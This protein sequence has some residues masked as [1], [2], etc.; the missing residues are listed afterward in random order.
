MSAAADVEHYVTLFDNNFLPQ[1][2]CLHASLQRHGGPHVL[3]IVCVDDAVERHLQRL[4]LPDVRLIRLDEAE[5]GEL[6]AVKALRTR[7]EYCWTITPF[8][9]DF[10]FDRDTT[11]QRV[12]YLDADLFFFASPLPLFAELEARAK[13]VLI[14]E[15]AY[16]PEY[17][18]TA[19]SGRFCVQFVTFRRAPAAAE[20]LKWWQARCIEWCYARCED[21]K[22]G[23]QKYLD[24]W[25]QLFGDCVHI[26]SDPDLTLAPWNSDY[27][28]RRGLR[29]E[30]PAFYHF[31]GLRVVTPERVKLFSGHHISASRFLYDE[32]LAAMREA[33]ARLRTSGIEVPA[34]PEPPGL[35]TW[36]RRIKY[37]YSGIV[38][39]A[40]I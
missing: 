28:I 20:V 37:R 34:L 35:I 13:H 5:T 26:F 36:L 16:A 10:V 23:D 31:H 7:A 30:R 9:P 32:Y 33:A 3:W 21:G 18:N 11:A 25:P 17:D 8:T 22:Y 1:G 15:H 19:L 40:N 27:R 2:L 24:Q 6:R 39:Y 14:T 29:H 38:S 4:A 12:T